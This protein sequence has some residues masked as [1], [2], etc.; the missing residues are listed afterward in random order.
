[1]VHLG[2]RRPTDHAELARLVQRQDTETLLGLLNEVP[3]AENDAVVVPPGTLHA[4]GRSVLLAEVQQ[5][6][7]LSIL[8]EW[9]GFEIDGQAEGHLGLGFGRAL[10]AVD[11]RAITSAQLDGL[12][13]RSG[14]DGPVFPSVADAWFRLDRVTGSARFDAGFAV[15]IATQGVGEVLTADGSLPLF[16]GR[17]VAIPSSCGPFT[18]STGGGVLVARPPAP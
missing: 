4:I 13:R 3:V 10:E 17:T 1:M 18:I 7:D 2:L 8:L 12:I 9:D 5:P 14:F 15:L 6:S 11:T 16:K